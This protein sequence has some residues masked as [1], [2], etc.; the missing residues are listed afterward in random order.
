MKI[1]LLGADGQVGFALHRALAPLGRVLAATR[2]GVLPGGAPCLTADLNHRDSLCAV[3]RLTRP[4]WIVN[5]AAYTAVDQA[6]DDYDTARSVNGDA[7]G[8][9]GAEALRLNARVL[10]FSTDYVFSG[11]GVRPYRE[12]DPVAP[13]NAYGRSKLE[14]ERALAASRV[15]HVVLRTAWVYGWRG[16]NF[17]RTMLRL[18]AT[19]ERLRVVADQRGAPTTAGLIAEVAAHVLRAGHG[20]RAELDTC[21]HL[22]AAGETTWHAFA[23]EIVKQAAAAGLIAREPSVD[24][25]TSGE[26]PTR[27]QRPAYSVLDCSR[28]CQRLSLELPD[29]REGLAA[30]IAELAEM[31][32]FS[33]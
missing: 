24:A 17:L 9:I 31:A 23:A 26:F 13:I 15:P 2:R 16:K 27:A 10:H 33:R 18:A 12:D 3:L 8:V 5:A 20:A 30:T 11:Q 29:W 28:L 7:L 6:E 21:Y 19:Q 32:P 14:G 1:L 22:A 25:I 4:S